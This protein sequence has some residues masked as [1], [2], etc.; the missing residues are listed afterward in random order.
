MENAVD[1]LKMG[2]AVLVFTMALSLTLYMFS[3]ARETADSVLHSSDMTAYM[4]YDEAT[5]DSE[6]REVG[7]ETIIPTLYRYYT[8]NY[9]IIFS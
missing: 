3:Q 9:T 2:F 1:A 8:E 4:E 7:L 5:A 6:N